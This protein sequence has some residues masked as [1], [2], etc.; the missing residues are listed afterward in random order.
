[1]AAVL[2]EILA[3]QPVRRRP[4]RK[5]ERQMDRRRRGVGS[6]LVGRAG[7]ARVG[8]AAAD[9]GSRAPASRGGSRGAAGAERSELALDAPGAGSRPWAPGW[10][11]ASESRSPLGCGASGTQPERTT[12]IPILQRHAVQVLLAAGLGPSQVARLTG[13]AERSAAGRSYL[14]GSRLAPR[15]NPSR[16]PTEYPASFSG[17]KPRTKRPSGRTGKRP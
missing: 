13:L 16:T 10:T 14:R 7:V 9:T 11:E 1:M 5:Q 4:R 3:A 15:F 2:P 8:R 6:A 17:S 12:M